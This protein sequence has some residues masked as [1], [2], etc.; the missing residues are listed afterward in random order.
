MKPHNSILL[1]EDDPVDVMSVRRAFE[2]SKVTNPLFVVGG[3]EE[4]LAFFRH[5]EQFADKSIFPSPSL[6]LLDL[7]MPRMSGL[8]ML[9]IL[10]SDSDLCHIPVV[11]LTTSGEQTDVLNSFQNGVAGYLRKPVTFEKFVAAIRIFDLYWTLS[12]MP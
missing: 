4:G 3:G 10:K 12:E 11:V 6:I 2:Q 1:V 5:E 9:S 8:E 7:K